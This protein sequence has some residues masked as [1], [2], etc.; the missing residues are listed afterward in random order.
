MRGPRFRVVPV[1]LALT[2]LLTGGFV[3]TTR[4]DNV[5]A[6]AQGA[7]T[8]IPAT[9]DAPAPL[10]ESLLAATLQELP[11]PPSFIRMV[12]IVLQPGA[13]VPVHT[14]PGPEF[15]VIEAGTLT[16][17][18]RGQA[19]IAQMGPDGK[20]LPARVTPSD[21]TFPMVV[22]DQI[23]YP[24]SVPFGFINNSREPVQLLAA[25]IL[26]AGSQR[27]PGAQWVDGTPGP[28]AFQGVTSQILGD[29]IANGWPTGTLAVTID[30]LA[31]APGEAIPAR[32]GPVM[33]SIER[34]AF[35]FQ[36]SAGPSPQVSRGGVL[37]DQ[38]ATPGAA[39]LLNPGDSVFFPGGMAQVP[40][41]QSDGVLVL[42]RM[43]VTGTGTAPAT[44]PAATT[45]TAA[46]TAAPAAPQ[47][48]TAAATAPPQSAETP[49]PTAPAN[50]TPAA[51]QPR[52]APGSAA[53]VAE[54]G[55]RL[56]D[57]P[58]TEGGVVAELEQ[59]R[60]LT[61]TGA[62]VEGDG[63]TW[64]PVQAVDDPA[65]AGFVTDEFLVPAT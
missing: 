59:G 8:P 62:P 14:H 64:Y 29:A 61:I 57:A 49:A 33:L 41:Q 32:G 60:E 19:V 4:I 6:R 55:V 16:V 54:D 52:F 65:V 40:R 38:N 24:Q 12:R 22:D 17:E 39:Y 28:N 7:A 34:G 45:P 30:R 46:T 3:V 20:P 42:L 53:T 9:G 15:G 2:L 56:R 50:Q 31:L 26:P 58:T 11:R 37:A 1:L 36:L 51:D 43:S 25:V 13:S 44:P 10:S 21:E 35:A 63:I 47:T 27:P 23:V 5:T 18:T 48:A